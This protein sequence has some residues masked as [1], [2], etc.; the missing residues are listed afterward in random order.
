[1]IIA[2][3]HFCYLEFGIPSLLLHLAHTGLLQITALVKETHRAAFAKA[4]AHRFPRAPRMD[5]AI[6]TPLP[7]T[8]SKQ[9]INT[10]TLQRWLTPNF[11][12]CFGPW[13]L[14]S[15]LI[16]CP[17]SDPWA[18]TKPKRQTW[19]NVSSDIASLVHDAVRLP[20]CTMFFYHLPSG[21][22]SFSYLLGCYIKVWRIECNLLLQAISL[23]KLKLSIETH[24]SAWA[25]LTASS[26]WRSGPT[27]GSTDGL[28]LA[29]VLHSNSIQLSPFS[30]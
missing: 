19:T 29:V 24:R 27:T 1:M 7:D 5:T 26:V 9:Q 17:Q 28:R 4:L 23:E 12:F 11:P 16:V 18:E 8:E 25:F 10:S 6:T 14:I 2:T 30:L 15:F 13:C 20:M 3:F 21:L 22:D